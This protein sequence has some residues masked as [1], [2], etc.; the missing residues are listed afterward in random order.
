MSLFLRNCEANMNFSTLGARV[1]TAGETPTKR[2]RVLEYRLRVENRKKN[3]AG[4]L[5]WESLRGSI[6]HRKYY[7]ELILQ[8]RFLY[9]SGVVPST[10][11]KTLVK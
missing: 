8:D 3:T 2:E 4:R 9:L 7:K 5:G 1:L 11:L 10:C 6:L